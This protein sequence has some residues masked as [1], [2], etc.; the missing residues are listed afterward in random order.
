MRRGRTTRWTT[1][2]EEGAQAQTRRKRRKGNSTEARRKANGKGKPSNRCPMGRCKTLE[3]KGSKGTEKEGKWKRARTSR[4]KLAKTGK[5]SDG[6]DGSRALAN[7][8]A[9]REKR[10]E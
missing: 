5:R 9:A 1:R 3:R 8:W 4:G 10:E 6:R 7:G 2:Q